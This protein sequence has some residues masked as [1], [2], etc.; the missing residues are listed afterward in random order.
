MKWVKSF[1]RVLVY[2]FISTHL[3][4][5]SGGPPMLTDDPGT[6]EF[7]KWEINTSTTSS[8]SGIVR[9][10]IPYI[11]A[12][13]GAAHNLQLKVESPYLITFNHGKTSGEPGDIELG[14]KYRIADEAKHFLSLGIYPQYVIR[15]DKGFLFP[16]LAE[17][18]FGKFLIGED[19]GF[20]FGDG[21]TNNFQ[22]GNLL[23][24][25]ATPKTQVMGE[26]FFQRNYDIPA[27]SEGYINFGFRHTLSE[28]F[29]LMG[30]FGS[31]MI[32]PRGGDREKFISYLGIQSVF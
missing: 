1:G 12:N 32:T 5:Q 7:R 21:G 24:Y 28:T 8:V 16:V 29:T 10:G 6:T 4:A 13:Y 11:D 15:G 3:F 26:F 31:Q 23:G 17:K 2:V 19:L 14:I 9:I 20:F 22:L 30:S 18:T 27:N 25:Q